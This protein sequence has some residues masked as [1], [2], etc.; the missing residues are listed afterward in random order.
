MGTDGTD[1]PAAPPLGDGPGARMLA[2]D[3]AREAAVAGL[4][5]A[6]AIASARFALTDRVLLHS[7]EVLAWCTAGVVLHLA[8]EDFRLL[9]DETLAYAEQRGSLLGTLSAH[10]WKGFKEW[11][12][13]EL[14]QARRSLG[15]ALEQ[16]GAWGV[17]PGAPH[18]RAFLTAV[19]LD[20]GDTAGARACLERMR[21][22]VGGAEGA[23]LHG[24]SEARVLCAERRYAEALAALDGVRHLQPAVVNPVWWEGELLRVRALTGLGERD[25]AERLARE[26]LL[27]ARTWGA[28]STVGR[29]LRLLGEAR[30]PEGV[31]ELRE[32]VALL[33]P[34]RARLEH[35]R[36]QQSLRTLTCG[37]IAEDAVGRRFP[38]A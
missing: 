32:A 38:P 18:C 8:D 4:D 11:R 2:A 26:Q 10:L 30:G 24:E 25:R 28:P 17:T 7:G 31:P 22:G 3:A 33:A 16:F 12:H 37:D 19:L 34:G 5:R 14:V 21:A 36:A 23:R 29:V 35:A 9:W 20:L 13:G 1:A 6:A 27:M 15:T